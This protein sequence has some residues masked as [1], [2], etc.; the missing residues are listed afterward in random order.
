MTQI[1]WTGGVGDILTLEATFTDEYRARISRMYWATR[2]FKAMAPLFK[3]LPNYPNLLEHVSLYDGE[4]DDGFGFRDMGHALEFT[5]KTLE[6]DIDDWSVRHRFATP[7]PYNYSS[8]VKYKQ[9]TIRRKLPERYAAV[10]PYSPVA[11]E[12]VKKFRRF[13]PED[14]NWTL[15]FLEVN[16]IKGVVLNVGDDPIPKDERLINLSNKTTLGEAFEITKG[17]FCYLGIDTSL[18]IMAGY[19]LPKER[20]FVSTLNSIV[21]AFRK[22]WYAPHDGDFIIPYLGATPDQVQKWQRMAE[23]DV[24]QKWHLLSELTDIEKQ[25]SFWKDTPP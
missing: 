8:F 2:A 11:A 25:A 9:A 20:M 22:I 3:K 16:Q 24:K 12:K 1:L 23:E 14:W 6:G 7:Q 19:V 15:D 17:C 21:W 18:S 13:E 4:Y 5:G 10:C